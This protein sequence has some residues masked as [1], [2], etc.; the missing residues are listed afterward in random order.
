MI[1][2]TAVSSGVVGT[3]TKETFVPAIIVG[4]TVPT[5]IVNGLLL[6]ILLP[7]HNFNTSLTLKALNLQRL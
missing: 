4:T 3:A 7:A 1:V 2:V 5:M 6:E